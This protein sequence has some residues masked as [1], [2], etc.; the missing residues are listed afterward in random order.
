MEEFTRKCFVCSTETVNYWRNIYTLLTKHTNTPIYKL[1]ERITGMEFLELEMED[2]NTVIC[3]ECFLK[4]N[5][6]ELA[7]E[8]V[9]KLENEFISLLN[10]TGSDR[11]L[12]VE[13]IKDTD[14]DPQVC[15]PDNLFLD[16]S[17]SS[18]MH[19]KRD[20]P[21]KLRSVEEIVMT[22]KIEAEDEKLFQEGLDFIGTVE[23]FTAIKEAEEVGPQIVQAVPKSTRESSRIKGLRKV[24]YKTNSQNLEDKRVPERVKKTPARKPISPVKC[25]KCSKEFLAKSEYK[26]HLKTH[27]DDHKVICYICGSTYKSKSAL[28]IHMGMHDGVSPFECTI[29]NKKF[30]QKGALVRHMP[31]HAGERPYQCDKCGKRFKHYSSFHMHQLSHDDIRTKKCPICGLKLRS[32]SHLNRHMRVH[33]G[34]KPY[35]CPICGQKVCSEV[36]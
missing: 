33:S 8:T 29:C 22:T 18:T 21:R 11:D 1:L 31:I 20:R 23:T 19:K 34:E 12:I 15:L 5:E 35:A 9:Q 36:N 3:N 32:N 26:L 13:M 16:G 27:E 10:R 7:V 28:V 17:E 2:S 24:E 30:T 6:Y 25:S 4:I 14:A